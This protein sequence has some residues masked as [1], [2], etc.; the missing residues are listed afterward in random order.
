MRKNSELTLRK[1]KDFNRVY[2]KGKSKGSRFTVI[3]YRKNGLGHTRTAYV[4]SKKVGNSVMRNRARRLMREAY[5]TFS[6]K[7]VSGYDIVMVA[8]NSINDHSMQEVRKTMYESV[9]ACGLLGQTGHN[10]ERK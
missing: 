10:N 8:R 5:N 4:A 1:Q 7:V 3:L 2:N 6:D 9:R